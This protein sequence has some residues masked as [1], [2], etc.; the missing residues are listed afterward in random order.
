MM[1]DWATSPIPTIH[2][3]FIFSVYFV[4]KIA[5]NNGTFIWA[6]VVGFAGILTAVLGP[7]IGSYADK[8][9]NR[10]SFLFFLT[11]LGFFSTS[12]LWFAKPGN[13]YL[14]FATIFSCLTVLTMELIFVLYNA[15]LSRASN[16]KYYGQISGYSWGAGYLGG[17]F[18][19]IFC[20]LI[21][22]FPEK[23][24][25]HFL[26]QDS[27]EVRVCMLFISF[28]LIIFSCPL[29]FFVKEPNKNKTT[30]NIIIYLKQGIDLIFNSKVILRYFIARI[31]YFDALATLF[32][33]G[34][35]YAA[36]V[37]KFNQI[38]ILY[39]AIL[40]N[41]SAAIGASIGGYFD[42]KFSA[43]KIIR[44]SLLGLICFGIMLILVENKEI[45][46]FVS[47]CLG[48]F[49]GPLQSSSRSLIT[50]ITP[51]KRG[52]QFFGFAIFSGKITSFLGPF[53]YGSLVM[54]FDNQKLGMLFVIILFAVSYIILGNKEPSK[55]NFK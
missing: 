26:K 53:I 54:L 9:G 45:F 17:I 52:A 32:A 41:I 12:F 49:I 35:I 16:K 55:I 8:K 3:T 11:L 28:W 19:L 38:E 42:D 40:I 36:K 20:L 46:W 43:F 39:F 47:F 15:L 44:I 51:E 24:L 14:I 13:D 29:F 27:G 2:T 37:F 25:F 23:Q 10:K 30:K 4:N 1:F 48:L 22:I 31:F 5:I 18:S 50:K 6:L 21:F 33:F 7:L 34:G